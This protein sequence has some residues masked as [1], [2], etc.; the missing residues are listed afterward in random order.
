MKKD[1]NCPYSLI[2]REYICEHKTARVT[3]GD[4]KTVHNHDGYEIVLFLHGDVNIMIEPDIFKM[5]RGDMFF[6][7]PLVFHGL[8]LEDINSYE[9]VV[10]N[11]QYEY[12]NELGDEDTDFSTLFRSSASPNMNHLVI[13]EDAL[14]EFIELAEKLNECMDST[15]FGH[16][17][18]A[19][20]LLVEFLLKARKYSSNTK[21]LPKNS[22]MPQVVSR[23]F[24]Y[25]DTNIKE[26]ITINSMALALHYSSDHL[27]RVFSEATGDSLK[28][29]INAKKIVLAQRLLLQNYSPY[30]VCFMVGYNNYS[31]F[32]RRFSKQ[33]GM[34]PKQFQLSH[35]DDA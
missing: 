4:I 31:S 21:P 16:T 17:V 7:S 3:P 5:K 18:L 32:S 11:I 29:Y 30:D 14:P 26:D 20:A 2:D 6:T 33:I 13:P 27:S 28:H 22:L 19:K 23:I 35:K 1:L 10:I 9:R 12:L 25:I 24:D 15:D 34:S 8:D